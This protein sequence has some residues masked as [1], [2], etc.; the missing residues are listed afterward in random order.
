MKCISDDSFLPITRGGKR[1]TRGGNERWRAGEQGSREITTG[2]QRA[3]RL[4]GLGR[5]LSLV[6]KHNSVCGWMRVCVCVCVDVC[7]CVCVCLKGLSRRSEEIRQTGE[8]QREELSTYKH[9]CTHT[10]YRWKKAPPHPPHTHQS[11]ISQTLQSD[12]C[13]QNVGLDNLF[14]RRSPQLM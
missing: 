3:A 13:G 5:P 4:K 6:I 12:A 2:Q 11:Q 7:V 10:L 9:T 1:E 8:T 14:H